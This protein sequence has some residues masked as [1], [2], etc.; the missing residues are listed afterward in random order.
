MRKKSYKFKIGDMIIPK[1]PLKQTIGVVLQVIDRGEEEQDLEVVLQDSG[2]I[3]WI[4]SL[5][6]QLL[7]YK[8]I[9]NN[10]SK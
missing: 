7:K 2:Q 5:D 3:V 6:V 8:K 9:E 10:T 1:S 4:S